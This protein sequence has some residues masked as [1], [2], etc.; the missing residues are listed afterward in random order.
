MEL[1]ILLLRLQRPQNSYRSE[2]N[3]SSAHFPTLSL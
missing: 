3:E 1:E 2:S